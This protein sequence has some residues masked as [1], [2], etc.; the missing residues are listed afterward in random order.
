MNVAADRTLTRGEDS[1]AT[2]RCRIIATA[3]CYFREIGYQK[4][5]VADIAKTLKMSPANVYRFF[6]SK[7]AI[8]EAV[9]E[10]LIGE[11]EALIVGIAEKPG[12]CAG[13]RLSAIILALHQDTAERF[14]AFPRMH[15]M[16]EAAIDE[17]WDVCHHHVLRIT[18]VFERLVI[19]GVRLGEFE[20]ADPGQA[21]RCLQTAVAR[22]THPLLARQAPQDP[23]PPLETMVAFL[24]ASLRAK[25]G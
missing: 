21:A 10:R 18:A 23:V 20:V 5:T 17:S 19:E 16:I 22:Y 25:Q 24:L 7:K 12:S 13:Q 4:T 11:V 8:N 2:T 14:Q 9:V 15:E 1:T 3:Q 6:E